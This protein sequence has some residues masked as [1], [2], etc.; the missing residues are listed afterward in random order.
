MADITLPG[1]LKKPAAV[2][3]G[4]RSNSLAFVSP[5][6]GTTQSVS[7]PGARWAMRLTY[8]TRLRAQSALLEAVRLQLRGTANR[9]VCG[10]LG[11]PA[12]RGRGGGTPVV[13]GANQTGASIAIS[14]L[15]NSLT[16]WALPG[17]LLGIGGEL[18]MVCASVD[19][20]GSGQATVTFEPP[21]R[22]SPAN[23]SAI[24]TA[25]PTARWMLA[26]NDVAWRETPGGVIGN[27][28][29]GHELELIEAFA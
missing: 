22:A 27:L 3:F 21:L 13:N 14:G 15:P 1:G 8:P 6:V 18:K 7:L 17:D 26:G 28:V 24:V 5:L 11:R 9:L 23:G 20:N 10:H 2:E 12:L 4:L 19:S 29:D 25:A 16:G